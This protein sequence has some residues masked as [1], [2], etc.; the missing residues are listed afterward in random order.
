LSAIK[1][2]IRVLASDWG[3]VEVEFDNRL[4][5][6]A[7]KP[8]CVRG[9]TEERLHDLM[10]L[11]CRDFFDATMRGDF[12]SRQFRALWRI[13]VDLEGC[14]DAAFDHAFS[15]VF[16][17]NQPVLDRW[18]ALRAKGVRIV[19]ASNMEEMRHAKLA[20]LGI[21]DLHDAHCLS[22]QVGA[23][24]PELPF[25][26]RLVTI[27]GCPA[28]EIVFVDDHVEFGEV[29]DSLGMNFVHYHGGRHS[30]G[31]LDAQLAHYEFVAF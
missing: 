14:D 31:H 3:H 18:Q 2:R 4:T 20:A 30:I 13:L 15:D 24:K 19:S 17:L 9:L 5:A 6:K 21:H 10:F 29:A 22:Y 26:E 23:I 7:L 11:K 25:F 1:P 16:T 8:F 28:K 12:T 27:A